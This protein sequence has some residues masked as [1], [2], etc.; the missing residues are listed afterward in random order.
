MRG[1]AGDAGF[2]QREGA[3]GGVPDGRDAGLEDEPVV[4]F[5]EQGLEVANGFHQVGVVL[6]IAQRVQRHDEVHHGRVDGAQP[7]GVARAVE[8]PVLGLADGGVADA[9]GAALFP[10]LE[11]AVEVVKQHRKALPAWAARGW[12]RGAAARRA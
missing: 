9:L 3:D 5:D 12:R 10:E 7:F 6:G 2:A 4:G 11:D 8:N 1:I